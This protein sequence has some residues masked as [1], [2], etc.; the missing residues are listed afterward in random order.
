MVAVKVQFGAAVAVDVAV[1][2][3]LCPSEDVVRV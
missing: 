1:P 3:R 2:V